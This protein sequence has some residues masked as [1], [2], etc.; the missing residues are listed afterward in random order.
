VS[1]FDEVA[2]EQNGYI[3]L[4][5]L[6]SA[7]LSQRQITRLVDN[8]LFQR[9][10]PGVYRPGSTPPT[11]LDRVRAACMAAGGDARAMGRTAARVH[12]LDG[13]DAHS[14]IE[15]TVGVLRGPVPAGVIVRRTRRESPSLV[16]SVKGIPVSTVNQTLLDYSFLTRRGGPQ[17]AERAVEDAIR[18]GKTSE[19][20]LRRFLGACGKGV[21][22]VT[23][24]RGVLD[25]RLDG[26]PARS[27]F[28]VIV[29]DILREAGVEL[30]V[31]RLLL[32]VPPDQKFELDLAYP[33]LRIDIEPM[34]DKWHS[35]AS[36]RRADAERRRVLQAI[37][38][39]VVDVSWHDAIFRPGDVAD[40]V[41]Q[42]ITSRSARI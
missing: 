42:A 36:Q 16:S 22:G 26:R 8:K 39:L 34:G 12:G 21:P 31:R 35:T 30:P 15:I 29:G 18:R 23:S 27:G 4:A 17:L 33:D 7:G 37:G 13:A 38:W 25:N 6:R 3:D 14:I 20:A 11:W 40:R 9:P 1:T 19:A 41:R 28:E 2:W 5:Q 10:H 24:L 32:S